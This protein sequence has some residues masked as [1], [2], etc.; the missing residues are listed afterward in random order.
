MG[1]IAI[2]TLIKGDIGISNNWQN[3][4][5]IIRNKSIH[6]NFFGNCDLIIFHEGNV[7]EEYK[8]RIIQQSNVKFPI[9]FIEVSNFKPTMDEIEKMKHSLIDRNP[10]ETGYSSMC[11]FWSY[12]FLKYMDEYDMVVRID[13]DCIVLNDITSIIDELENRH[14]VFPFLSGENYRYRLKEFT[15]NYFTQINPVENFEDEGDKIRGPYTNFCGFN[16]NKIRNDE[17]IINFFNMIEKNNFI[18]RYTWQDVQ[19]WGLIMKNLL[20]DT[21]WK[22]DKNIKYIH[23]SHLDYVN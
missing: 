2:A 5:V 8:K 6:K 20:R 11:K 22:E 23:L 12:G 10:V 4:S 15:K 3:N 17:R 19:L 18:Y 7:S 16:L 9:K 13:D 21:D 14:I 1:K